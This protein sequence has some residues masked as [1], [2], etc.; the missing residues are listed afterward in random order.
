MATTLNFPDALT[1]SAPALEL[2]SWKRRSRTSYAIDFLDPARTYTGNTPRTGAMGGTESS[3]VLLAEALAARGH[4]VR[5]F[6]GVAGPQR[7]FGVAYLPMTDTGRQTRGDIGISVAAPKVFWNTSFRVP[8][9]WLHNPLKGF[10]QIRK[11]AVLPMLKARPHFVLLGDYHGRKVPRWLPSGGRS[12]IHH[13]IA[14]AF[15]REVPA[16]AAPPPCAIF[17]SQPYRGLDWLLDLWPEVR[18]R[19]PHARF[20]VFAPKAHQ[21]NANA[22]KRALDGVSFRGSIARGALV[23]ELAGARIQFIP[24]HRDETYCLAAAEAVASGVPVVTLGAGSL[25]ERVR[26][27]KTG[28]VVKDRDEFIGRSAA[29]LSDDALWTRMHRACLADDALVTWDARAAEW[30]ALFERLATQAS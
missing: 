9:L 26:D 6:N 17:T 29:L 14:D 19:V 16:E 5:V 15:R 20:D 25:S 11:G 24:G 22:A 28:F 7:M 4:D 21:A 13:G 2:P 1:R 10:R 27:G 30:E 18:A 3:V 23:Q 12:I 8:V